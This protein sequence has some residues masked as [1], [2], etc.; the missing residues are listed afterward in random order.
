MIGS[1]ALWP[2]GGGHVL[3]APQIPP[4][5]RLSTALQAF[6]WKKPLLLDWIPVSGNLKLEKT[7]R[8]KVG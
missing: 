7:Q 3:G 2:L 1:Q 8:K 4:C 5:M 6:D